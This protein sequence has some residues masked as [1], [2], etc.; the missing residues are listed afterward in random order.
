[1]KTEFDILIVGAGLV[2]LTSALACA[3]SGAQ[4]ALLD[5]SPITAGKDGRASA[6]S[7]TSL[8]LFENLGVKIANHLQPIRDMLV[9]CLLYTSPSPRD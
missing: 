5:R 1:M 2:G 4:V 3:A 7:T 6:L 9:T 8:R